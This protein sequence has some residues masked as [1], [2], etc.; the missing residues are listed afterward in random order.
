M[1]GQESRWKRPL[2]RSLRNR[3]PMPVP[4]ESL[5]GREDNLKWD[6]FMRQVQQ[7]LLSWW[8]L[9]HLLHE[10]RRS[11]RAVYSPFQDLQGDGQGNRAQTLHSAMGQKATVGTC[12]T[13]AIEISYKEKLF[14]HEGGQAVAQVTWLLLLEV[15]E[16]R[17]NKALRDLVRSHSWPCFEQKVGP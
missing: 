10:E 8:E 15:P 14:P 2:K 12:W 16:T 9:E 6:M 1:E 5:V 13:K 7:M 11:S 17:V 3:V 4:W